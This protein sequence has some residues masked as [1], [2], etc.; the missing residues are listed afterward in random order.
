MS[1]GGGGQLS[2]GTPQ[3]G[4]VPAHQRQPCADCRRPL[5]GG[6]ADAAACTGADGMAGRH[7][8]LRLAAVPFAGGRVWTGVGLGRAL[9]RM[10]VVGS[11]SV[12]AQ[13]CLGGGRRAGGLCCQVAFARQ[14]AF[15]LQLRG[16]VG[17]RPG[18]ASP[19]RCG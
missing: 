17:L 19:G 5:R 7:R 14:G 10:D 12:N 2:D 4:R 18:Q 13:G 15:E 11:Q 1:A 3:R 6:Q 9:S 8:R 16:A